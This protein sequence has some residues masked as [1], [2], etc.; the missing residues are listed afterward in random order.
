MKE[1]VACKVACSA[2]TGSAFQGRS[3]QTPI[4]HGHRQPLQRRLSRNRSMAKFNSLLVPSG[5]L[6]SASS[7]SHCYIN[8]WGCGDGT[9]YASICGCPWAGDASW[10]APSIIWQPYMSSVSLDCW[11]IGPSHPLKANPLL[12]SHPGVGTQVGSRDST[13][14][15]Q[16]VHKALTAHLV[17]I[18][19]AL[20]SVALQDV[21]ASF[22]L[23]MGLL[24]LL[25]YHSFHF[26]PVSC[27]PAS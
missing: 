6:V 11:L 13:R 18:P 2:E 24:W 15:S 20:A 8:R 9:V 26:E 10:A 14:R 21:A 27:H 12:C 25:Y 3:K 16:P 1:L 5:P 17:Q 22:T 23:T 7:Q 19:G 4:S